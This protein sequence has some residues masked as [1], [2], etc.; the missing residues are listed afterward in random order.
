LA[1]PEKYRATLAISAFLCLNRLLIKVPVA[2]Y[3]FLAKTQ[4]EAK[5]AKFRTSPFD[6]I[7]QFHLHATLK[8]MKRLKPQ[9]GNEFPL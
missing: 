5:I 8:L 1:R 6:R 9:Q 4:R 7:R 3:V 2:K